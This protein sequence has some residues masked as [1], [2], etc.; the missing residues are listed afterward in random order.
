VQDFS[1]QTGI[2]GPLSA[3]QQQE[4]LGNTTVEIVFE[5]RQRRDGQP[6]RNKRILVIPCDETLEVTEA[7][8]QQHG[9]TTGFRPPLS[10]ELDKALM[11]SSLADEIMRMVQA[12]ATN[13]PAGWTAGIQDALETHMEAALRERTVFLD[14]AGGFVR[15]DVKNQIM[16]SPLRS[17][18]RSVGIY[19]TNMC[20]R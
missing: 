14:Q 16:A 13:P 19:A 2:G 15:D 17:F 5:T 8:L 3:R 11:L 7:I 6:D 9:E 1:A 18:H 4:I 20:R 12:F 10:Y